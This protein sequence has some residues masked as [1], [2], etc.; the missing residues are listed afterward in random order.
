MTMTFDEAKAE[1]GRIAGGEYRLLRYEEKMYSS[2]CAV[3]RCEVYVNGYGH[4]GGHTWRAALA[5][6]A[7][8]MHGDGVSA[9][10]APGEELGEPN[11]GTD[12]EG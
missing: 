6:L 7:D 9:V 12:G 10:E 4:H 11:G 2:G 8:A 3:S 1:L 5:K